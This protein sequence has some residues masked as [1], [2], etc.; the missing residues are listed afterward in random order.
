MKVAIINDTHF[1]IRGDQQTVLNHQKKFFDEVFFPELKK[2][3]IKYLFHLGDLV[4][5]RKYINFY[6]ASRLHED[7]LKPLEDANITMHILAG[8]HDVFYKN[9][10]QLNTFSQLA[11]THRYGNIMCHIEPN[12]LEFFGFR[13]AMFPWIN[14]ENYDATIDVLNN[15]KSDLCF[16]HFEF[17]GFEMQRGI[18]NTHG[19][20]RNVFNKYDKIFSGHYHQKSNDGKVYYLGA[21]YQMTWADHDCDRGFHI[22]DFETRDLEFIKNPFSLFQRIFYNDSDWKKYKKP[23]ESLADSYVKLVVESKKKLSWFDQYVSDILALNP[24]DLQIIESL[25]INEEIAQ[26]QT[27][28]TKTILLNSIDD[29]EVSISKKKLKTFISSLY[30]DAINLEVDG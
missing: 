12:E 22:F 11:L 14:S 10:N 18:V 7:F 9:S 19:M 1:G 23:P 26:L 21:P 6:T 13:V 3:E 8:N 15:S 5:R 24:I 30:D 25:S 17:H 4:D 29:L 28:D 2:R 20:S 16:G 27:E